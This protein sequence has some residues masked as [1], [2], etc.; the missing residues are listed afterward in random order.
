MRKKT[1]ESATW[2]IVS[3]VMSTCSQPFKLALP[4]IGQAREG[5]LQ[6]GLALIDKGCY[7]NSGSSEGNAAQIYRYY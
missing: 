5:S 3:L 7:Q 1:E 4:W 2:W 6:E